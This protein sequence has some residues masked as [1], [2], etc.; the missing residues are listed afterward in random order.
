MLESDL[1]DQIFYLLSPF[2]YQNGISDHLAGHLPIF[3]SI[4]GKHGNI[5]PLSAIISCHTCK[6]A[7]K[8]KDTHT[9][10]FH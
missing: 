3:F 5:L 1:F 7:H 4:T 10:T 2:F 9:H 6:H 8:D